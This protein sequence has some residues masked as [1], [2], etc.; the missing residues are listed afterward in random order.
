MWSCRICRVKRVKGMFGSEDCEFH[1][2][3]I[4]R[5]LGLQ[6]VIFI[7]DPWGDLQ[8]DEHALPNWVVQPPLDLRGFVK[9]N[10]KMRTRTRRKPP[11]FI[12]EIRERCGSWNTC[13]YVPTGCW[14]ILD[15][16]VCWGVIL[17]PYY[18]GI[19]NGTQIAIKSPFVR[20]C[21]ELSKHSNTQKKI[22][23]QCFA[24]HPG[25]NGCHEYSESQSLRVFSLRVKLHFTRDPNGLPFKDR[26]L[27][28]IN[29]IS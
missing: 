15:L 24:F 8:F 25:L 27:D 14:K 29:I 7:L 4:S 18:H 6:V 10:S 16:C 2:V 20:P 1:H 5:S 11:R 26:S 21:L 12:Q 28:P 9:E 3:T 23:V 19:Q 22:K 13:G 17:V